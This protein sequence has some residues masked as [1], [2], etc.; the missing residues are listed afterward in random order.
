MPTFTKT[1]VALAAL[2]SEGIW[3]DAEIIGADL[4]AMRGQDRGRFWIAMDMAIREDRIEVAAK[5]AA[6]QAFGVVSTDEY[7]DLSEEQVESA[8]RWIARRL[9]KNNTS[10][11]IVARAG[12]ILR[13]F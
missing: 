2:V 7:D 5:A 6:E 13:N 8:E 3:N 1:T 11:A 4:A 9:P 12:D 10:R